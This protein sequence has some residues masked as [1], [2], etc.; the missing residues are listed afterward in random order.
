MAV[1]AQT[2]RIFCD[3]NQKNWPELLPSVMAGWRATPSIN[4]TMFSPYRLLLGEEMRLPIDVNLIPNADTPPDVFRHL[5]DIT[6]EFS[7]TREMAKQNIKQAQEEQKRYH[8]QKAAKPTFKL[9]DKV[10][11]TNVNKKKGLNPKL[12]PRY[13]GPYYI[14]DV[15]DNDTYI[16][17]DCETHRPLKSRMNALRL[18]L[19]L[20]DNTRD[21]HVIPNQ[22]DENSDTPRCDDL[23]DV[24]ANDTR[25][26]FDKN[27]NTQTLSQG[28]PQP[29]TSSDTS[30][31]YI[32]L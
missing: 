30:S 27:S 2:L 15:G 13:I 31:G 17:H 5:Q 9:G 1:L 7:V 24:T 19:Y 29:S 16:L 3:K 6:K 10:W 23:D 28:D 20:A 18:K 11:L 14:A 8:D 26:N 25:Q 21:I 22:L 4:S 32:P 12:Q